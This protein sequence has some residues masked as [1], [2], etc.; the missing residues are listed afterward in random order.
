MKILITCPPMLGAMDQLRGRFLEKRVDVATP[1]VAQ[2]VPAATLARWL[3]GVDGWIVGDDPATRR[4]LAAGRAGRL[5]A[6][7]KWGVGTDNVDFDACA[8]LGIAAAHTPGMFGRE[9]ADVAMGYV[10]ALARDTFRIDREV[11]R[12]GWPKPAGI[13]LAGKTVALV[14]FGDI[15]RQ[16]ARRLLAAEM[17]VIAYDPA[18]RA[19]RGLARVRRGRWPERL[20]EA[21]FVVLCCALTPA[22]RH[23]LNAGSLALLKRGVRIVNVARGPLIDEAAL[24]GALAA[25]GVHSAALDVFETEPLPRAAPLRRFEQCLFGSHNS[26]NTREAVLRASHRAIDL[27]FGFLRI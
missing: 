21:D 16:L 20:G 4:V 23:L 24:A 1:A 13:S 14:G 6:L 10:A 19:G 26:S 17:K 18:F 2:T 9:V 12:G 15:G 7:V 8:D 25:G 27:L 22:S 3:P 11:R 5:R